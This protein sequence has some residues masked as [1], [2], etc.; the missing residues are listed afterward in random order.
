MER[1]EGFLHE[2]EGYYTVHNTWRPRAFAESGS[3]VCGKTTRALPPPH[4]QQST[5][6]KRSHAIAMSLLVDPETASLIGAQTILEAADDA[7]ETRPRR[8]CAGRSAS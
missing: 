5:A 2:R 7:A 3:A 6:P 1:L 8:S 4:Q